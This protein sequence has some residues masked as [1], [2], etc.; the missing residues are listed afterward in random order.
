MILLAASLFFTNPAPLDMPRATGYLVSVR[1]KEGVRR[2]LEDRYLKGDLWVSQSVDG[3]WIDDEDRVFTLAHLD[4]LPPEGEAARSFATRD[5]YAK[6]R[7]AIAK[8]QKEAVRE[9]VAALAPFDL[10][11]KPTRPRQLP[12]GYKT[13]DYWHGTNTSAIVCAYLPEKQETWRLAIWELAEEDDWSEALKLFE[14]EFL[15]QK[16]GAPLV[17][18]VYADERELLRRD[19]AHS[20]SAY[21]NWH[22]ADGETFVVLDDLPTRSLTVAYTND[23]VKLRRRFAEVLPTPI[24]G[25][26]TLCVARIYADR[27]EY[28][29]ALETSGLTNMAWSAAYWSPQR[30]ELVAHASPSTSTS[31]L[32]LLSTLRHE[33]FH[34]YLSYATAMIATSPWLNEGYAQYFEDEASSDWQLSLLGG[35]SGEK[36]SDEELERFSL[37]LPAL[38]LM[39][40][41]EFYAG[42]DEARRVKYRLAWSVAV[43]LEKGAPKVRFQ[44]F[45]NVKRDYIAALLETQD[46]RKA[47]AAAFRSKDLLDKFVGDWLAYW[48]SR[49]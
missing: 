34:Q 43:F 9:A 42:S 32:N 20:V 40:Y 8:R 17:P 22:V 5:A 6:G 23:L 10:P 27:A 1:E 14:R 38:L 49:P 3:R 7:V 41:D 19:A 29:A 30:R 47:T 36:P 44:P 26:N 33:S 35:V 2:R 39:D 18:P 24:D 28:L 21:A 37:L 45:K 12:R 25:S 46:M 4:V 31:N 11:E 13:V 15:D 16:P 48:K